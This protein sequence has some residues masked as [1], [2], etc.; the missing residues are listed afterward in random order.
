MKKNTKTKIYR[1]R[2]GETNNA[3]LRLMNYNVNCFVVNKHLFILWLDISCFTSNNASEE[4]D[5]KIWLVLFH[6]CIQ[7][8][9]MEFKPYLT[10]LKRGMYKDLD[11]LNPVGA[12][13]ISLNL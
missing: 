1:G 2:G 10:L 11:L 12:L 13:C 6:D 8:F 4:S 9:A 5:S 7:A 3:I